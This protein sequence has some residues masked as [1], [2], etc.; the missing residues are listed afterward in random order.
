MSS[1]VG[2][3][4]LIAREPWISSRG[5]TTDLGFLCLIAVL[6][7]TVTGLVFTF[8]FGPDVTRALGMSG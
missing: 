6:G 3:F 5:I 4:G 7:L 8:G 1:N 2:D